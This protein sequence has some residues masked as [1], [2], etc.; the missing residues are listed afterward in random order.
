MLFSCF[1]SDLSLN[2]TASDLKEVVIYKSIF[3]LILPMI[4]LNGGILK[5]LSKD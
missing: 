3:V 2:L 4:Q 1:S 5:I